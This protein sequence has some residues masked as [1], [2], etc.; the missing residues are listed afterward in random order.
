MERLGY[1]RAA[2]IEFPTFRVEGGEKGRSLA[3]SRNPIMF[4]LKSH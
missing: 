2:Y 4:T 1:G 3:V